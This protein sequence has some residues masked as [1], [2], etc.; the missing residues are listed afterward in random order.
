MA[1]HGVVLESDESDNEHPAAAQNPLFK[2]L[3]NGA[4]RNYGLNQAQKAKKGKNAEET[5]KLESLAPSAAPSQA[6]DGQS[7]AGK[8]KGD[9]SMA[10]P[11]LQGEEKKTAL[12][13]TAPARSTF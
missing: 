1:H 13:E 11:N 5:K 7:L 8:E 10:K 4:K 3:M 9:I 2:K 12:N 6:E